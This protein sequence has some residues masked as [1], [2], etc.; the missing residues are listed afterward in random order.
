MINSILWSFDKYLE[1]QLVPNDLIMV[2]N[3]ENDE[4]GVRDTKEVVETPRGVHKKLYI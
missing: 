3:P 1:N 2:R 4:K